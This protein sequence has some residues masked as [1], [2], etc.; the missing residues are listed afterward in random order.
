MPGGRWQRVLEPRWSRHINLSSWAGASE[1]GGQW[2]IGHDGDVTCRACQYAEQSLRGS[3]DTALF[4]SLA[5]VPLIP[6]VVGRS[7]KKPSKSPG[8]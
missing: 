1:S 4:L 5:I 6:V 7:V 8:E 3:C 2:P